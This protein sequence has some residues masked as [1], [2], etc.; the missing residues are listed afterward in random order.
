[1]VIDT[2]PHTSVATIVISYPC[3][4]R[5]F[6]EHK[7]DYFC[8]GEQSLAH[9]CQT[10][11]VREDEIFAE[12]GKALEQAQKE[13]KA[14]PQWRELSLNDLSGSIVRK[15]NRY[16]QQEFPTILRMFDLIVELVGQTYPRLAAARL[17]F[18]GLRETLESH[19]L[20]TQTMI[21]PLI[22]RLE[23]LRAK[24]KT[25]ISFYHGAVHN[26]IE[27]LKE[28]HKIL[29]GFLED[30]RFATNEYTLGIEGSPICKV[31]L[32]SLKQLE[33]NI[34]EHIHLENNILFPRAAHLE[35][36]N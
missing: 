23:S 5:V 27:V 33:S 13:G 17:M 31:L 29:A 36:V 19:M 24:G 12:L 30:L 25:S 28:E 11:N 7:I 10:A 21:F 34:H 20:K 8:H 15:Y 35:P 32:D 9:A 26:P 1:M 4:S 18:L 6:E 2:S 3:I 22:N 16:L 14:T